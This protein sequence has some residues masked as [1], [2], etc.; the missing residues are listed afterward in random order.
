MVERI[1]PKEKFMLT[2][3]PMGAS[4]IYRK[5]ARGRSMVR[6]R[7]GVALL[8]CFIFIFISILPAHAHWLFTKDN[9]RVEVKEFEIRDGMVVMT[10]PNGLVSQLSVDQID[11]E[12]TYRYNPSL[13]RIDDIQG[14]PPL[15]SDE[16]PPTLEELKPLVKGTM[17]P[18]PSGSCIYTTAHLNSL[19]SSTPITI[20]GKLDELIYQ[21]L[22]PITKFIQMKPDE[23]KQVSEKTEAYVF[24]DDEN[25]YFA[26]RCY[27]SEPNK[28]IAKVENR[29]A[30]RSS[31]RVAVLMDTFHDLR[32]G[33]IFKVNAKGIQEDA[34]MSESRGGGGGRFQG[35]MGG[36][37]RDNSWNGVWHSAISM[38]DEG[39]MAEMAI[40]FETLKYPS[41]PVQTWGLQLGRSIAR[42]NE[43]SMWYPLKRFD[44]MMKPSKCGVLQGL[45]DLPHYRHLDLIP[46]STF[47]QE[48]S[49]EYLSG[50]ERRF[51]NGGVDVR[52]SLT[53]NLVANLAVNPDFGQ[54]EVDEENVRLSRW[55]L[56]Y[57]EKREFFTEGANIFKNPLQLFFS[58]RIG[59]LLPDNSEHRILF[60]SKITGKLGN[61]QIGIIETVTGET[62][63]FDEGESYQ[64]EGANF[65]VFRLQ[66]DI[67]Q[68][69]TI[70]FITVN[71]D[72]K[73]DADYHSQRAHGVDLNLAFGD[74]VRISS[75]VAFSFNPE[76]NKSLQ[77]NLAYLASFNY[78]SNLLSIDIT[79]R[80]IGEEFDISQ[81]GYYPEV[82]R[83]GNELNFRFK[84]F[85]DRWGIRQLTFSAE[86]NQLDN[87][88]G[89]LERSE[90]GFGFNQQWKNFW[91]TGIRVNSEKELYNIFYQGEELSEKTLYHLPQG[92]FIYLRIPQTSP[93]HG[94][95]HIYMGDFIDYSD[96]YVGKSRSYSIDLTAKLGA[97]L[98]LGGR[99]NYIQEF[100][101]NGELDEVR[102]LYL[103]RVGYNF[104]NKLRS[105]L[106]AQYNLET[107]QLTTDA[108]VS[109]E[110]TSRSG[111]YLGFRDRRNL[112][113]VS[114][115]DP[116]DTRLFFKFS[117]LI[118]F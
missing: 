41:K 20:D 44:M 9:K 47:R 27:D 95:F 25:I 7:G 3:E 53:P 12:L 33:Y 108:L 69:S 4:N 48:T 97:K 11:W 86:F 55:E 74:H 105:R 113:V 94:G 92:I 32:S 30:L 65:F 52:Y 63:Y 107:T 93:V 54:T 76:D 2:K 103:L 50:E 37:L 68:K 114:D 106:L 118:S 112:G 83:V 40:P 71:R 104:T 98:R 31:D 15:K 110:L 46:F 42:K 38:F 29:D 75:Q 19:P 16:A 18:G 101:S 6:K 102:G 90:W 59:S 85:I 100:F 1:F 82:D 22:V 57:P 43:S 70:G 77:D 117:Y 36:G 115:P 72:Q 87:H 79:R 13:T 96:C 51:Y 34:I 99:V 73:E 66:R 109:Y 49:S 81:I 35:R 58:R 23:G 39:W 67:L 14:K 111:I 88:Q 24:Y 78:N 28:I 56:F 45:S 61:Q 17:S 80:D 21:Q 60:G 10:L 26:F 5:G 91:S 84:P 8:I 62:S 89:G 64:V 116:E